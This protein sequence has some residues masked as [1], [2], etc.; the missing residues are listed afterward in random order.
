MNAVIKLVALGLM[1]GTL[2]PRVTVKGTVRDC[3]EGTQ[4]L[5]WHG[6]KVSAFDVRMNTKL[7]GLLRRMDTADTSA[8]SMSLFFSRYDSVMAV[9]KRNRG[10]SR[11]TT[12]SRGRFTLA[13]PATD[14]VL[15][16]A[17]D[18][19]EDEPTFFTYRVVSG[20]TSK[21]IALNIH[22]DCRR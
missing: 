13:F 3:E 1:S 4:K 7:V 12:D 19:L 20:R 14:S 18:E 22:G 6:A 16:Y 21:T 5:L 15:V 2:T 9:V 8:T 17:Y 10:L 11:S